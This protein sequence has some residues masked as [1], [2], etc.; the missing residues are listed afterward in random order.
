MK[1]LESLFSQLV[2]ASGE[3]G[4]T[5]RP[6]FIDPLQDSMWGLPRSPH[7]PNVTLCW[8]NVTVPRPRGSWLTRSRR[9]HAGGRLEDAGCRV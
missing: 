6:I 5:R 8:I 3:A 4:G 9:S 2:C 7:Y 1:P